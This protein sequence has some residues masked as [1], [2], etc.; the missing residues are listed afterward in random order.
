[1]FLLPEIDLGPY[2]ERGFSL[3]RTLTAIRRRNRRLAA[4]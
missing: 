4:L 3:T 2:I 1:M